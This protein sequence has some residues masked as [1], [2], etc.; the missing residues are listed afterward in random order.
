[1]PAERILKTRVF[2][3]PGFDPL[4]EGLPRVKMTGIAILRVSA[5]PSKIGSKTGQKQ[6]FRKS[7]TAHFVHI[8]CKLCCNKKQG[9]FLGV[10]EGDFEGLKIHYHLN[11]GLFRVSPDPGSG[12]L[13]KSGQKPGPRP[14]Q[15]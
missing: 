8:L 15:T 4:P 3:T 12:T 6:V 11:R 7:Q 5:T 13:Q 9:C 14:S 10:P 2:D 1:M